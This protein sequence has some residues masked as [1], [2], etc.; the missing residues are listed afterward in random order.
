LKTKQFQLLIWL[1]AVL[2]F[3]F[4]A[5]AEMAAVEYQA[6]EE[7]FPNPER[8][9]YVQKVG[10]DKVLHPDWE[11]WDDGKPRLTVMREVRQSGH[12]LMRV[13]FLIPEFK[14]KD[15]S[16][17]FLQTFEETFAQ[18]REAGIKIIPLF[19]YS[20]PSDA[21]E[22]R[23]NCPG[24][25]FEKYP[26]CPENQDAP[27]ADVLR[28][29]GQ[30]KPV[31]ARNA[32]VI[33]MWD[34]GFIGPWGEWHTSTNE[35]VGKDD[36]DVNDSTRKIVEK[37]LDT[38]PSNR[39]ITLRYPRHKLQLTG[40]APLSP[41]EAFSGSAK[42]RLGS[43]NDCFLASNDDWGTYQPDDAASIKAAKD[44]LHQDNLY[45]PV[46]GETC[47]FAADAQPYIGCENALKELALMRY[48]TLNSGFQED[49][50]AGWRKGGCYA[51]IS[52]RLGYRLRLV[53]ATAATVVK[54]GSNLELHLKIANDGFAAPYNPRGLAL[55]LRHAATGSVHSFP[56]PED[57]RRWTPGKKRTLAVTI[58]LPATL[59]EGSY[60][61]L[62][63]LPDPEPALKDNPAYAIRLANTDIWE[64]ATGYNRLRLDVLVKP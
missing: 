40:T 2:C 38:V 10:W 9:F 50:L 14:G 17:A 52:K 43:K 25:E 23:P 42:A 47:N 37:L 3:A 4:P 21:F 24:P 22:V 19:S 49:V 27:L 45:V 54:P 39:A 44:F 13:Y 60:D 18:A 35:L 11:I 59:P 33:A 53:S 51:E 46:Q 48:S 26:Q 30:L 64:E 36:G 28:H 8:G 57:P 31:I 56:L 63:H 20:W 29:I 6:S 41:D 55:V 15:L 1:F 61:A 7:D 16:P 34:A 5:L 62:L 12:S 58:P 32:D